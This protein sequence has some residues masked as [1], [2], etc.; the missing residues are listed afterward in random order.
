[1]VILISTCVVL[2]KNFFIIKKVLMF[3]LRITSLHR[4]FLILLLLMLV[5]V[6]FVFVRIHISN[7]LFLISRMTFLKK[8]Y[9]LCNPNSYLSVYHNGL[10]RSKN[11]R[12]IVLKNLYC[13]YPMDEI[14]Q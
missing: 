12:V 2:E 4:V 14:F 8:F 11:S 10:R 13:L 3:Y 6:I 5:I 1:M 7:G 9:L